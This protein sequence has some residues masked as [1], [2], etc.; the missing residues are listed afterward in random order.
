MLKT[1]KTSPT[2]AVRANDSHN[3]QH[4]HRTQLVT[5]V[6]I[7]AAETTTA[8]ATDE[9]DFIRFIVAVPFDTSRMH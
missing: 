6:D 4:V 5:A 3:G 8:P 9:I 1:S 7:S 2:T